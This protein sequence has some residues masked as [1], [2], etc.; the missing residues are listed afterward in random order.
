MLDTEV[1]LAIETSQRAGGVALDAG[2][3]GVR[4]ES[5]GRAPGHDE[6]LMPAI[7][8][9]FEQAQL[10]PEALTAVGVS[11]GPGGFTGLRIAVA[12]AKMLAMTLNAK[13]VAVPS[14]MVA[15]MS[16]VRP[17]G[18]SDSKS[19]EAVLVTLAAKRESFWGTTLRATRGVWTIVDPGRLMTAAD[20]SLEGIVEV[21]GD[22]YLPPAARRRCE[23]AGVPVRVPSFQATAC[24]EATRSKLRAGET[25]DPRTLKPLYPRP[26]EAVARWQERCR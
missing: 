10:P 13:V 18:E 12:I 7:K 3:G 23:A 9:L 25:T 21:L 24:L 20:L 22:R 16:S 1:I 11:I 8:R 14:A 26:P 2:A 5:L 19:S 17:G 6:Q 15:A 4:A